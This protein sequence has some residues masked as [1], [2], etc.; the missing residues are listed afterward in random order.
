MIHRL[1]AVAV[2]VVLAGCGSIEPV[3]YTGIASSSQLR[4]DPNDTSGRVPYR[5]STQVDWRFYDKL[6][7]DPVE[8]YR[9][10]DSQFGD[11]S[12]Q[13]KTSLIQYMQTQF[14]VK[15]G[16]RFQLTN[17]AAPGTLR[18][19]LTL[20]G[21][22]TNTPFLSTFTRFDIGGGLYNGVQAIRG[23]EGVMTGSVIY[24]VEIYDA[25]SDRLLDAS[26]TKQYPGAYNIGA[27]FGSLTA[28][29]SG[30]K[31]GAAALVEQFR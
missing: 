9:G 8:I 10:S 30:I 25:P 24:A 28:A 20:T 19:K 7:L 16:S 21:A 6:I 27:T 22:D 4:S 1:S 12:E 11:M 23:R 26:I 18:I 13:D 2:C 31:K 5:Y 29:Q 3:A 15:L 14:A 17:V